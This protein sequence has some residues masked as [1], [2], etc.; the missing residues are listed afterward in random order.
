MHSSAPLTL[1]FGLSTFW[2]EIKNYRAVSGA[3]SNKPL[4]IHV[5][6]SAY[7][8]EGRS[9]WSLLASHKPADIPAVRIV[10]VL[11]TPW[12][13]D[14]V[15]VMKA[16]KEYNEWAGPEMKAMKKLSESE[17]SSNNED[18]FEDEHEDEDDEEGSDSF[19]RSTLKEGQRLAESQRMNPS[20]ATPQ[21]PWPKAT[22]SSKK[23]T[24]AE[25]MEMAWRW[26]AL[27]STI[28]MLLRISPS[29]TW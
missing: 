18:E 19:C 29:Q 10:L 1:L 25:T 4:E 7:P 9:D 23:P 21:A 2:E 5:P 26:C 24:F 6:G 15:P 20:C 12:H 17:E 14:N 13:E 16:A 28:K 11:G 27:R 8:F 22:R 3:A